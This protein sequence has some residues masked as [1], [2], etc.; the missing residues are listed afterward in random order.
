[1]QAMQRIPVVSGFVGWRLRDRPFFQTNGHEQRRDDSDGNT[2]IAV[3]R[4]IAVRDRWPERA[5]WR[6][7]LRD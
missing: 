4:P 5:P 6:L 2:W 7:R 1:M 3:E